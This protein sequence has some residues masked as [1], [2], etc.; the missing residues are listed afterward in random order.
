MVGYPYT[1]ER[2]R[3]KSN[4]VAV[5]LDRVLAS[6]DWIELFSYAWVQNVAVSY[7]D[8]SLLVVHC[9]V[10]EVYR[11]RP[12]RFVNSWLHIAACRNIVIDVWRRPGTVMDKL[13]FLAET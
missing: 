4:W 11:V 6:Q 8:H 7:S 3:G 5:R 10:I 2:S 1:W 12:F 13:K 9:S